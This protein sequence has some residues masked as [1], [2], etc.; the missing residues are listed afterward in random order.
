LLGSW[1][2]Y[3]R[4][5]PPRCFYLPLSLFPFL[6]VDKNRWSRPASAASTAP[7]CI[8]ANRPSLAELILGVQ[9]WCV[10]STKT[11]H[12]KKCDTG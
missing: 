8:A 11:F 5:P 3:T 9:N 10:L 2:I 12:P 4:R 6:F 1:F 7:G